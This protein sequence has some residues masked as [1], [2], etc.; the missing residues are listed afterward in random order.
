MT[1]TTAHIIRWLT[2][3]KQEAVWE[4]KKHHKKRSLD[5]N[6]FYWKLVSELADSMRVSKNEVH[7][8]LLRRYGQAE[9]VDGRLVTVYIPDTEKAFKQALMA[10]DYHIKPTSYVQ[11]GSKG[12]TFRAYILLRG[13]RTY[14]AKEMSVLIDGA[15]Q[16]CEQAGIHIE[17]SSAEMERY[18]QK[19]NMEKL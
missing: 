3:Q 6:G 16:E 18:G 15:L 2:T 4:I 8:M 7:N 17:L 10:E 14:N 11:A 1:G 13:S 12:Q 19:R 5:A 9:G